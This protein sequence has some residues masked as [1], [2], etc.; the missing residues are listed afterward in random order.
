MLNVTFINIFRF[1]NNTETKIK[2][3]FIKWCN[4][5]LKQIKKNNNKVLITLLTTFNNKNRLTTQHSS[6]YL[7]INSL[8]QIFM[9]L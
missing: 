5:V 7:H 6:L 2:S 1:Q 9:A 8:H 4:V 3:Y